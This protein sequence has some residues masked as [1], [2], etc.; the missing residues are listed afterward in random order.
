MFP[1]EMRTVI[2]GYVLTNGVCALV[3]AVLWRQN[4][5]RFAGL[6][7]WLA[8]FVLQFVGL[9]LVA[10]RGHIPDF[11]SIVVGNVCLV[12]GASLLLAGLERFVA[13]PGLSWLNGLV[14]VVYFC[15]QIYFT[16]AQPNLAART[17]LISLAL[18]VLSGWAAWLLLRRTGAE[19][20]PVTRGVGLVMVV[21]CLVSV[22]RLGV[23]AV[24]PP[25]GDFLQTGDSESVPVLIYQ[26][27]YIGLTFG[28][29]LM[30]NQR[31]VNEI[32]RQ[33]AFVSANPNPV[34]TL[35]RR[36]ALT[37]SNPAA[38]AMLA[39]LNLPAEARAFV[40]AGL[41]D[42][43]AP[44]LTNHSAAFYREVTLGDAVLGE[45][46]IWL[47]SFDTLHLYARDI[48]ERVRVEQ[49]RQAAEA[50][51][52][53]LNASLQTRIA[54]RTAQ[55]EAANRELRGE[56]KA[57]Q[58]VETA[59]RESERH[60]RAIFEHSLEAIIFSAPDGRIFDANPAACQMLGR[61]VEELRALGRAAVADES[62]PRLRLAL[63]ERWQTG[64]Y[65][66]EVAFL[67]RDGTP[68]PAEIISTL[69]AGPDGQPRA[70]VF[71]RDITQRKQA[72]EALRQ[73]EAQLR[74][75]IE[76]APEGIWVTDEAGRYLD[77]N[78]AAC[79]LL[80][81]SRE[82]LLQQTVYDLMPAEE[83][84]VARAQLGALP[85]GVA[86]SGEL[87]LYRQ[88]ESPRTVFHTT[89]C[90]PNGN[91]ASFCADITARKLAER[92]R[93]A[94]LE[95]LR[96]IN[97][98]HDSEN[99]IRTVIVFFKRWSGCEAT[100]IRLRAGDDFPYFQVLGFPERFVKLESRLCALDARGEIIRD[101]AGRPIL[102][103]MCGNILCG[104][105]DPAQPFFT[106]HGSFWSNNTTHLLA[107][108]TEA[109]RQAHTRNRC[110]R[111]GYESVALIPL[112]SGNETFGLV[113]L[114]DKHPGRFT[115]ELI[116]QLERLADH[117]ANTLARLQSEEVVRE[118]EAR[119]R[120]LADENARLLVVS[121]H[122]AATKAVLL[123]EVNHRVK[124]NLAAIVGLLYVEQR[125]R[126]AE[127]PRDYAS[128]VS[129]LTGRIQSL[130]VVHAL[131]SAGDW[132][133]VSL[134]TLADQVLKAALALAPQ[135]QVAQVDVPASPV[136][137]T[138]KQANALG[139]IFNELATNAVK[140]AVQADVPLRL[141]LHLAETEGE[142]CLEFCDNGP[143]FPAEVLSGGRRNVGLYLIETLTEQDLLG[144]MT[145]RNAAGAVVALCL[146]APALAG[147]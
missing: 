135:P 108:T 52:R 47:P 97:A 58:Q 62:D 145:L 79:A 80:G 44:L 53:Q 49:A 86:L 77:V 54:E 6:G 75:Y 109:D 21:F 82:T 126:S 131:L 71:V 72:E 34:L 128:L 105:F 28:L 60:Y 140:Y 104:R 45:D 39:R 9:M 141:S 51:I 144:R 130:A 14:P 142:V 41:I 12:G 84:P 114:N 74:A 132:G 69:L 43:V 29:C 127:K 10:L 113:Q 19:L 38:A 17:A 110:N 13:K 94:S 18:L 133:P 115:P 46:I 65:A 85:A 100:G 88:D 40:P 36:G 37:F 118:S 103:C 147:G 32:Q 25:T 111:E 134:V 26:M 3:L 22:G 129:D 35:D 42:S 48:T 91:R 107:T 2:V 64:K 63:D 55:L 15:A 31:L 121:Q 137:L 81:I 139:L 57:R 27:F 124:N 102:E 66:G 122:E 98:C 8:D 76:Y 4:H 99:L 106:P 138:P 83:V 20:R 24:A 56:V 119:Y 30:V 146:P 33:A 112:R 93:A 70:T 87:Q 136:R 68:F 120:K 16:F 50:E 23:A 123:H 89:V 92:G 5:K 67:R 11:A 7:F 96:L 95:L 117:V 116:E 61:T 143:G 125:F 59:L 90:L 1:L 73:S 78:P 101:A